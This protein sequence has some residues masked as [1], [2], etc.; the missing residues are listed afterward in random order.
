MKILASAHLP[1]LQPPWEWLFLESVSSSTGSHNNRVI[2]VIMWSSRIA[3]NELR[4]EATAYPWR[5]SQMWSADVPLLAC[6]IHRPNSHACWD[7][8]ANT[9]HAAKVV[10][11][12]SW[13]SAIAVCVCV[14]DDVSE[15]SK[16]SF[17]MKMKYSPNRY[18]CHCP[19]TRNFP[20]S[21]W[22]YGYR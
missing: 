15:I 21:H 18:C 17:Q 22:Q 12:K 14:S 9:E 6:L 7:H 4:I 13:R 10:I 8:G 2:E 1:Y 20:F 5:R 3:P 16:I 19:R 11:C